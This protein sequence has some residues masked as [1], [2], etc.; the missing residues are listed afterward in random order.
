[1]TIKAYKKKID[2]QVTISREYYDLLVQHSKAYSAL[3]D[4]DVCAADGYEKSD[5]ALGEAG[6]FPSDDGPAGPETIDW[7]RK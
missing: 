1:M 4:W 6:I 3:M 5:K 2:D 7:I